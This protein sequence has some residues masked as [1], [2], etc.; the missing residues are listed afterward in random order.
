MGVTDLMAEGL[1]IPPLR[2]YRKGQRNEEVVALLRSNVRLPAL[3]SGWAGHGPAL[4]EERE[5]SCAVGPDCAVAVDS[6]HNLIIDID[7]SG[8]EV[9]TP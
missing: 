9:T 2:L 6:Q 7:Y 3:P 4:F 1:L 8:G 5:T